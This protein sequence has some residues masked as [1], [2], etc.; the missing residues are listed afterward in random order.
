MNWVVNGLVKTVIALSVSI[1]RFPQAIENAQ[2]FAASTL[3]ENKSIS[4]TFSLDTH[5]LMYPPAITNRL[6][7]SFIRF[8]TGDGRTLKHHCKSSFSSS[9]ICFLYR[10]I[11]GT[12]PNTTGIGL[13]A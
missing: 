4:F 1:V 5:D 7:L 9:C 2:A 11:P 3:W 13:R 6:A 12:S 10:L 8:L